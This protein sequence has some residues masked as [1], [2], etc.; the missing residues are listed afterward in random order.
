[1]AG[2]QLTHLKIAWARILQYAGY[3][4]ASGTFSTGLLTNL[5]YVDSALGRIVAALASTNQT[6]KT[7]LI[8]TAKHGQQ[9]IYPNAT[10]ISPTPIAKALAAQNIS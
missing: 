4:S 10:L 8:V 7:A 1:M 9:P 3:T 2:C 5:N 6:S